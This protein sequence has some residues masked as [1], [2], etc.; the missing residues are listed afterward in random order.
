MTVMMMMMMM[1]MMTVMMMTVMMMTVM[2]MSTILVTA[3]CGQLDDFEYH[4]Q[5]LFR[6]LT[7]LYFNQYND[8]EI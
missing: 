2:M 1:M 8:C 7:V 5:L 4:L 3:H 6:M